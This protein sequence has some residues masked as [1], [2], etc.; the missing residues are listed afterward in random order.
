[1]NSSHPSNP[2]YQGHST[3]LKTKGRASL[4]KRNR[5]MNAREDINEEYDSYLGRVQQFRP[6]KDPLD[7]EAFTRAYER[8]DNEYDAAVRDGD[9]ARINELERLLCV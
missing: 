4:L 1:M 8:W 5:A 2:Q 6:G 9:I 7:F 3:A